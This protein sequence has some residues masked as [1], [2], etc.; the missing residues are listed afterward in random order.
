MLFKRKGAGI[1]ARPI[2]PTPKLNTHESEEFLRRMDEDLKAPL[3]LQ[4]TPKLK[5]AQA[6]IRKDAEDRKR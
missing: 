1:M 4:P 5:E 2:T 6:L 3:R